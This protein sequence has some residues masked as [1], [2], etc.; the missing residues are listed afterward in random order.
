MTVGGGDGDDGGRAGDGMVGL[1]FGTSGSGVITRTCLVGGSGVI[2]GACL[3]GGSGDAVAETCVSKLC[4]IFAIG[5]IFFDGTG[6][7]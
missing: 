4:A 6:T 2:T 1:S 7:V 3:V 5:R